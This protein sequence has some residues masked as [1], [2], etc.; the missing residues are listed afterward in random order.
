ME[1][2]ERQ[3]QVGMCPEGGLEKKRAGTW[4]KGA[5]LQ[6]KAAMSGID[7]DISVHVRGVDVGPIVEER[8]T[9]EDV[10]ML[11]KGGR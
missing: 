1:E 7:R 5:R 6:G 8:A 4:S 11:P 9:K 3:E 2:V 10:G